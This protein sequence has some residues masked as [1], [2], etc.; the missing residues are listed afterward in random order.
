MSWVRVAEIDAFAPGSARRIDIGDH[1]VAVFRIEDD[2]YAIGDRCSHAEAS[3]SEGEVD[4]R[5]VECPLHGAVFDIT[6]GDALSL[7]ASR[8][9]PTYQTRV[10]DGSI[11]L[12]LE[13]T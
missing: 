13:T 3:L 7:P 11:F 8:P 10:R 1:R 9:V 5:E 6:T 12:R 2:V 4:D